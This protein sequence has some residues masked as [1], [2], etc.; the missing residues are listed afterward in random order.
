MVFSTTLFILYFLPVFLLVYNLTNKKWKNLVIL[1]ASILFYS[2]G[3]PKFVFV[4]VGSTIIDFYLVQQIY[5]SAKT[6]LRK[7]LLGISVVMNLGLLA[8]FKYANFFVEN[9][10]SILTSF[11]VTELAWTAVVLP[12]G[13]SFYTFQT[14]TYS[15]DVY[16]KVHAPLNKVTDYL[17]YIMSFPQMIAGPIVRF[18]SIADQITNRR[19]VIDDKL[20]GFYRFC[21]G[22]AKK[23]LIANVMAEQA[24]LIF[25]SELSEVSMTGAWIGMLAYTFQIYFDFS[26]Y[27]DM[28]IGLGRMMGFRFPEN[29]N[30]PYI[31]KN[32]SE[33]WRRWHIT[34]GAFMR[35]YL[36]IPLGGNRVKSKGRLF[37]NLWIVFLLSGLW[38]GAAWN[39]VIWGAYHGLFLIL[40]RLFLIRVLNKLGA[41]LST[42]ITFFIVMIGWV[43]FRLED[44]TSIKIYLSRLFTF[45]FNSD[46]DTITTFWFI[47]VFA[48]FFS[49]FT[50]FKRGKRIE[51]FVLAQESLKISSHFAFA[52]VSVLLLMLSLISITSSGFNPFIYFR[53]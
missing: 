3:A 9:L 7:L 34:L 45:D 42:L 22:L 51:N 26:G 52:L 46:T 35:D 25:D 29:F 16:R 27:S 53:F 36:Y 17:M 23:V 40:D 37:F 48:I 19:E 43:I 2:W 15:I 49:F 10:N 24:D 14:L 28:A 33:F 1:I 44:L 47:S 20:I 12:I 39:F 11:G 4:I 50:A 32:I 31:S 13:I 6:K 41:V 30:S 21:I 18:S 5:K 38:H 8:Y